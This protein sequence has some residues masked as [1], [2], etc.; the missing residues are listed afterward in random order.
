MKANNSLTA[1]IAYKE[2]AASLLKKLNRLIVLSSVSSENLT[3]TFQ[4]N[5]GHVGDLNYLNGVMDVALNFL[6]DR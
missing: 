3:E 6:D 5:W 4:V 1:D 2:A